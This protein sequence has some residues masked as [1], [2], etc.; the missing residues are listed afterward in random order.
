M[1]TYKGSP[2]FA[3]KLGLAMAGV[4]LAFNVVYS[5]ATAPRTPASAHAGSVP[6]H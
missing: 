1:K 3:I 6:Q 4:L 5:L 2:L